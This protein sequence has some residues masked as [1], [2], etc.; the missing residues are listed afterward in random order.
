MLYGG[1]QKFTKPLP[2]PTQ[3]IQNFE[4]QGAEKMKK[5]DKLVIRNYIFG[6][7]QTGYFW[8]LLGICEIL[9]GL[10]MLSQYLRFIAAVM[11]MPIVLHIFLFHLF[12][13][14]HEKLELIQTALLFIGNIALIAKEFDK[15]KAL[16][17]I[18]PY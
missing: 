11:L 2:P 15:W 8:Q 3:M 7:K 5:D 14:P 13:E 12:L 17:V 10:M 18:K 16:V 9:F 4:E 6:L 1:Y